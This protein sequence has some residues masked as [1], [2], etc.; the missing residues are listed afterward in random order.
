MLRLKCPKHPKYDGLQSPRASCQICI[1]L[2]N[3]RFKAVLGGAVLVFKHKGKE[4]QHD[5]E[6]S[7]VNTGG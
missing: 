3:L 1:S 4:K 7:D 2:W 5:H 6:H